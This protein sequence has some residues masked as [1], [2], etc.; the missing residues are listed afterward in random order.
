MLLNLKLRTCFITSILILSSLSL[1][2]I[3]TYKVKADEDTIE[4][5]LLQLT[6]LHPFVTAGVYQYSGNKT[7]EINGDLIFDL[8]FS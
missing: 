4:D 7:L 3:P 1:L 6:G 2:I 5:F 8:Y